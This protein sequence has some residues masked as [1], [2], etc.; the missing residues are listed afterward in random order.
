VI[1]T[2]A[3]PEFAVVPEPETAPA[4]VVEPVV[5]VATEPAAEPEPE[6]VVSVEEMVAADPAQI[7]APP[8]KPKRGWWR[9]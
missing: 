6:P 4:P 3:D 9:R 1:E 2:G 8:P 7:T 5:K